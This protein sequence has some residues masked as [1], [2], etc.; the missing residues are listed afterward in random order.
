ML[1]GG[2]QRKY[3]LG[4]TGEQTNQSGFF[5]LQDEAF[6]SKMKPCNF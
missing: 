6:L 1:C 2:V 3:F 4:S 5:F